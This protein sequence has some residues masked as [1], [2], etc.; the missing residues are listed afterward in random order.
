MITWE[1]HWL[2]LNLKT[3]CVAW[4]FLEEDVKKMCTQMFTQGPN[5]RQKK[6]FHPSSAQWTSEFIGLIYKN[7]GEGLLTGM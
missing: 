4:S 5:D 2:L 3:G 7:M 1:A 6:Q